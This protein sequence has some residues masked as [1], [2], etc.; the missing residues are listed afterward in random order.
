LHARTFVLRFS[1]DIRSLR[2]LFLFSAVIF[3]IGQF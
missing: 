3:S 2:S 1:S